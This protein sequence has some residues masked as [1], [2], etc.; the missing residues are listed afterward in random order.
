[1]E[2]ENAIKFLKLLHELENS[3]IGLFE[4]EKKELTSQIR[5]EFLKAWRGS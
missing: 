4:L 3:F 2:K 5:K 1:M